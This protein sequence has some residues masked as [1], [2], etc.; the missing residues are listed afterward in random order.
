[1]VKPSNVATIT[2]YNNFQGS[3][4]QKI[5]VDRDDEEGH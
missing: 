4:T 3:W 2:S 1:M 5:Q